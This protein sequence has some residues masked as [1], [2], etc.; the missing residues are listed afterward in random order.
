[1]TPGRHLV[2]VADQLQVGVF[3]HRLDELGFAGNPEWPFA[4]SERLPLQRRNDIGRVWEGRFTATRVALDEGP[5]RV[6]D[7]HVSQCEHID[8]RAV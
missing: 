6:I 1:V 3:S 5:P 2:A 7:V 4:T 8:I